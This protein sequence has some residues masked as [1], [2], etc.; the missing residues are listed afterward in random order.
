M[1]E[2]RIVKIGKTCNVSTTFSIKNDCVHTEEMHVKKQ[3]TGTMKNTNMTCPSSKFCSWCRLS[4]ST[5]DA[6]G[7]VLQWEH[8]A[9]VS[10]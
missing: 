1:E 3:N 7:S 6:H 4:Q 9:W 10:G 8:H 2:K 5:Q